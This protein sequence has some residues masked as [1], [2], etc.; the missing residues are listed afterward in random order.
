MGT[1]AS[2]RKDTRVAGGHDQLGIESADL[3]DV[4]DIVIVGRNR[5]LELVAVIE[6]MGV[7]ALPLRFHGVEV[8][9]PEVA[10]T[11]ES[12]GSSSH[13]K[14]GIPWEADGHAKNEAF[15]QLVDEIW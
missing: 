14:V 7:R 6:R 3:H 4:G 9:I 13:E 12:I 15:V 8:G 11:V 10:Q 2:D 5:P 1:A